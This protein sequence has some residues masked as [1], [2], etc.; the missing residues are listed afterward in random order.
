MKTALVDLTA[1]VLRPGWRGEALAVPLT[2]LLRLA[3]P[4][5]AVALKNLELALPDA[6]PRELA[7]LLRGTYGHMIR[8]GLETVMLQR[9]P[10]LALEW[11]DA[12]GTERLDA[13][14]GKAAILLTG[15]VG[16]WELMACWIAQRGHKV[17][18]IVRES[19][20]REERG[21]IAAM[22]ERMGVLSMSK[23]APMTRAVSLLR[24]GE[25]LG[26]L[27]DQHG[28]NDG[29]PSPFFGLE[30]STSIGPAVFAY[31][32]GAPLIPIFTRRVAPCRH[33]IRVAPPI[34]WEK[35]ASRD[36]TIRE[37]TRRING[38]IEEMVREAPDQWLAQ[39]KRFK[40]YYG[41]PPGR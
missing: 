35:L 14:R 30:T 2:A 34:E 8:V 15:H 12:E 3:G 19:D 24:R 36:D 28:G 21:L 22:R 40:E 41:N 6:S 26:I 1:A 17:T 33:K 25:F 38:T 20:D 5:S 13:L 9:D 18:A 29:I 16:N 27:P 7:R 23:R 37:I 11:V 32:T 4:R 39:H 10:K 31:L